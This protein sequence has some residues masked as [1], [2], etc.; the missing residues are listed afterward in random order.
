MCGKQTDD[1]QVEPDGIEIISKVEPMMCGGTDAYRDTK[2]P[3]K[4]LSKDMTLFEVDSSFS[5]IALPSEY[6]NRDRLW[7]I[8]AFAIRGEK[9]TFV[10]LAKV[11][12]CRGPVKS[13][14]ALVKR[15]VMPDLVD[16][17]DEFD[18][19]KWNGSHSNTYG[20]PENF[21]GSILVK[22]ASGEKISTSNNQCPVL[23]YDMALRMEGMFESFMKEE[24]VP[25][26][27][28]SGLREIRLSEERKDGYVRATLTF[29]ADGTGTNRKRSRYGDKEFESEKPVDAETMSNIRRTI[30]SCG[31][32]AWTGIPERDY[33]A[34]SE[35][36]MTFVFDDGETVTAKDNRALPYSVSNGF[37]NIELEMTTKHRRGRLGYGARE[38][39]GDVGYPRGA[40]RDARGIDVRVQRER[41][42]VHVV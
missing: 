1:K 25:L 26:K 4:I 30:D 9:G 13:S 5:M 33:K 39:F 31:M 8:S 16:L 12:E 17:V 41:A 29:N 6:N 15:D 40:L 21:G 11:K 37:F 7:Y 19:A 20:L 42:S 35:K 32:L 27:D 10:N 24:R 18:L 14:L 23:P 34:L 38:P 36:S 28:L 2:A 22:Y 3:K